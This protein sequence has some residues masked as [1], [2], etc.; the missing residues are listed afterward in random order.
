MKRLAFMLSVAPMA[1]LALPAA[2]QTAP[3]SQV[4][5]D[6]STAAKPVQDATVDEV[7]VTGLRESLRSAQQIKRNSDAILDA[8]VAEDIGKLPDNT[9][10]ETLARIT[11]V[12]VERFS[13]EANRVLI[14]G[15]PDVATT[16]NGREIF[17]AEL[18]RV[19]LQD[20]P[21]QAIAG[22][23]VYKSGTADIVEPGLAGLV[24]VRSRRPFDFKGGFIGGGLRGT[25]NDQ[26]RKYDPNGNILVSDRWDTPI[27]EIGVLAN[28]TYA[29]SQYRNAVRYNNQD[30]ST[31]S[32]ASSVSPASAGHDFRYPHSVGLYND[33]GKRYRPSAN[34]ALQW[35]PN[36]KLEVYIDGIYQ[37]YRGRQATDNLD[38]N[39]RDWDST[40]RVDPPLTNVTLVPGTTD[41]AAGFT[42]SGGMAPQAYRSTGADHT[43]TYQGA[44]GAI[45]RGDRLTLSTDL[46]YEDSEYEARNWSF[47][48]AF[49]SPPTIVA[50][51]NEKDGA[52]FDITGFNASDPANYLWRGYYERHY[53]AKGSGVQ[54]R[55]DATFDT[56]ASWLPEVKFG[57]R[58]TDRDAS[59]IQGDRYAGVLALKIPLASLPVGQLQLIEDPFR[60]DAQG[61]TQYLMPTRDGIA[62]NFAALQQRSIA[63]LQQLV[64]L[65]PN[66]QNYKNALRDFTAPDV[67]LKKDGAFSATEQ[68][69]AEYVQA[70]YAFDVG[71]VAIDG[72]VGV[73]VVQTLGE[74]SGAS[75]VK[76]A[77]V[78][79]LSPKTI[80][81]NYTDVLPNVSLRIR[82]IDKLQLRL[83]YTQTRTR[84]DFG[85]LNPALH[86][87][88]VDHTSENP[89]SPTA[90]PPPDATGSGGN[91]DLLPLT[92]NNYDVSAEYYFSSTG[93]ISI[94]GFY[95]DL[96]GFTN[97]Y[98]RRIQ[99]PVYGLVELSRPENSGAGKIKGFEIG[100]QT[101][102]DFLPESLKGFGVQGNVTYIDGKNRFPDKLGVNPAFVRIP[103]LSK[104]TYNAAVFYE[105][106]G[107][108]GRLS[109]NRRSPWVSY[110]RADATGTQYTGVGV[111]AT[112]RLDASL[113]YDISKHLTI[114]ADVSNLLA[115]P[116]ENYNNYQPDRTYPVDVRYEGRYY[117]LGLRFRFGE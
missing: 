111:K 50:K 97:N 61:F 114:S 27:G 32:S 88:Q 109:Y 30:I 99:D 84:V 60:G 89:P 94:A 105:R 64:V 33:G 100:A 25:Y 38:V 62:G 26:T 20:F 21:A 12:Q 10:A 17:T 28:A 44:V 49:A 83:G 56:G 40:V 73:R 2:A 71:S 41:Q 8:V 45:W 112:S 74:F 102:L 79:T 58:F 35:R 1:L 55:G 57:L 82:P 6:K 92:S 11:G 115:K 29:Q 87:T 3:A 53:I 98:T 104:W 59:L 16:Y 31:V 108:T 43:N 85:A 110:Y 39:L 19:Q 13:D 15:L 70:K 106:N 34:I 103:G 117:G 72:V 66:D 116:F 76:V 18:R 65:Y 5:S 47:D 75:T 51:F 22:I 101:F 107:L 54:W 23:E 42:K 78:T 36:D 95:R 69:Y 86:I 91:P 68:S 77:G 46:A 113:S 81:Q 52:A 37:G 9:A 96:F 90:P 7:V 14:R 4:L 80:R 93:N 67:P 48:T 24:N 63:A